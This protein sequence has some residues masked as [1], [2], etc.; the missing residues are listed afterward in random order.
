VIGLVT[1]HV[2][3]WMVWQELVMDGWKLTVF[4]GRFGPGVKL[5]STN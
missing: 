3:C 4:A 5:S 2:D 1:T